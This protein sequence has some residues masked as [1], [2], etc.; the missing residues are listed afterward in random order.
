[1]QRPIRTGGRALAWVAPVLVLAAGASAQKKPVELS[2]QERGAIT[3]RTHCAVCHG[4][5]GAGDGPLADQLRFAP[6]D[7]TRLARRNKGRFDSEQVQRVIDGRFPIKGHGGGEMPVWGDVF[8][9]PRD[10]YSRDGVR[11]K[12]IGRAHV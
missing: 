9:E 3:Y 4:K 6:A 1:M 10:G 2:P 12:K 11:K 8:L 5:G 7:L